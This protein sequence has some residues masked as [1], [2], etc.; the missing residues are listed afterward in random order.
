MSITTTVWMNC[1]KCG[2]AFGAQDIIP[3]KPRHIAQLKLSAERN[4]WVRT[5]GKDL[6]PSCHAVPPNST[7]RQP[8]SADPV[9]DGGD[10][11]GAR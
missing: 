10:G 8:G 11:G 3:A 1:D 6:C 7:V 9:L 2:I 5:A 4:G